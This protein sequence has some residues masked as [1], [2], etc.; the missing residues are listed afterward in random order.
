MTRR[1]GSRCAAGWVWRGPC[2]KLVREAASSSIRESATFL[3]SQSLIA[4][5][6]IAVPQ[7]MLSDVMIAADTAWPNRRQVLY[8][9]YNS[10]GKAS[11]AL[12]PDAGEGSHHRRYEME[13]KRFL[14]ERRIVCTWGKIR[15][16]EVNIEAR[17]WGITLL[18]R[19]P[20]M[21]RLSSHAGESNFC[22]DEIVS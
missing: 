20:A 22:Y 7:L 15:K 13:G 16:M 10:T 5:I 6:V 21:P 19:C 4:L 1:N 9:K 17:Y 11:I 2:P 14:I 12:V 3:V 8:S 18:R